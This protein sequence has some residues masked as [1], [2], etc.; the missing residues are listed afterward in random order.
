VVPAR[1]PAFVLQLAFWPVGNSFRGMSRAHALEVCRR[2]SAVW[3]AVT[4]EQ[5]ADIRGISPWSG[6]WRLR[7]G[8]RDGCRL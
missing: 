3:W 2:F 4:Y 1:A 5:G 7:S 6:H 8:W